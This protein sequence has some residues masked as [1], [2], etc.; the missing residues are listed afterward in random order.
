VFKN[1][2]LKRMF[3]HKGEEVVGGCKRLNNEELYNLYALPNIIIVIIS[4]QMGWT[5]SFS[6]K[7]LLYVFSYS[8]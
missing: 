5:V 7:I 6:R 1:R 8:L 3:G 4:K 2:V